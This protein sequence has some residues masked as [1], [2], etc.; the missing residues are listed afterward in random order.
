MPITCG[1]LLQE[2]DLAQTTRRSRWL[3]ATELTFQ[4]LANMEAIMALSKQSDT[5]NSREQYV[6]TLMTFIAGGLGYLG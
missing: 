4:G 3:L 5:R 2:P 1:I 6:Q